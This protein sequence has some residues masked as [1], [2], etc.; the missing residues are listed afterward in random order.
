MIK[1][2]G[3]KCRGENVHLEEIKMDVEITRT[4]SCVEY[5]TVMMTNL[6]GS[7]I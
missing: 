7:F 1:E 3:V 6:F 2:E 4:G 5:H